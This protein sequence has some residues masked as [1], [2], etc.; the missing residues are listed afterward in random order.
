MGISIEAGQILADLAN[1]S[2]ILSSLFNTGAKQDTAAATLANTQVL[3]IGMAQLQQQITAIRAQLSEIQSNEATLQS[4]LLYALGRPQQANQPVELPS[5]PPPGYGGTSAA[6]VWAE[7]NANLSTDYGELVAG[8]YNA[9]AFESNYQ[10]YVYQDCPFFRLFGA[11]NNSARNINA[12]GNPSFDLSHILATDTLLGFI[13]REN[14]SFSWHANSGTPQ[15]YYATD[16]VDID[17]FWQTLLN[18]QSFLDLRDS[19]YAVPTAAPVW[20]GVSK[21]TLGS[22][23][24][25]SGSSLAIAGPMDGCLVSITSV[26]QSLPYYDYPTVPSWAKLGELTFISDNGDAETFQLMGFTSALYCPRSMVSAASVEF[27]YKSGIVGTV[28]PW[29]RT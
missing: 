29:T 23:T 10:G 16:T 19:L 4:N 17:F 26:G 3:V 15:T 21:V 11:L 27:R 28:T 13:T 5:T 2:S 8:T 1:I 20:P 12:F 7:V 9:I 6:G 22:S 14:P 18:D 25:F 24:A